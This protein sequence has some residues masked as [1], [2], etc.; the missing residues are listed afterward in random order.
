MESLFHLDASSSAEYWKLCRAVCD[1]YSHQTVEQDAAAWRR[2]LQLRTDLVRLHRRA[3]THIAAFVPEDPTP[4]L[5][6]DVLH[7]WLSYAQVQAAYGQEK[8]ARL[9]LRH[10]QN[11]TL[12]EQHTAFYLALA[13]IEKDDLVAAERALRLGIQR[14]A[15]PIAALRDA[16][17]KLQQSKLQQHP[18]LT[19]L[20]RAASAQQSSPKRR[21]TTTG[22]VELNA[23]GTEAS[24]TPSPSSRRDVYI[25]SDRNSITDYYDQT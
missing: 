16:L 24:P 23:N 15:Q 2:I 17:R 4:S 12:G 5:Q 9:T 18:Q 8:D 14:K 22:R 19:S 7:I 11:Q 10:I 3:T 6:L 21:K 13:D 25:I 20:K 1:A